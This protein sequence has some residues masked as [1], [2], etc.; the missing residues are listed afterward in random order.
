MNVGLRPTVRCHFDAVENILRVIL[1]EQVTTD[2]KDSKE[3]VVVYALK[4]SQRH[5]HFWV[6]FLNAHISASPVQPG[7]A[8]KAD[9]QSFAKTVCDHGELK[10][11]AVTGSATPVSGAAA[12][13]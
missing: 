6:E 12:A 10:P 5:T 4:V 1:M 2:G 13:S 7:R 9:F 3:D 8:Q 11:E